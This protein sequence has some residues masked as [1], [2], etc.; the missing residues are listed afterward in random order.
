M[1]THYKWKTK[2]FSNHFKIFSQEQQVGELRKEGFSRCVTGE[3]NLKRVKFKT[4]GIFKFET[5]ILNPE[6]EILIGSI[7]FRNWKSVATIYY[8]DKELIWQSD[9]FLGSKW[10]IKNANGPLIKFHSH[11]FTGSIVAYTGDEILL[12]TGFYIRNYL[13]QRTARIAAAT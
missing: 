6:S 13:K 2:L 4:K 11:A 7:K 8:Q 1:E 10:S 9:N 3:L 12:L 5:D